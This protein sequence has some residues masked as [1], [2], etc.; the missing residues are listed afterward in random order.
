MVAANRLGKTDTSPHSRPTD[1]LRG[2]PSS[3]LQRMDVSLDRKEPSIT[4]YHNRSRRREIGPTV[5]GQ[6]WPLWHD[7]VNAKVLSRDKYSAGSCVMGEGVAKGRIVIVDDNEKLVDR[8]S[9]HLERD[10]SRM[11]TVLNAL[12]DL[13]PTR[14]RLPDL[15]ALDLLLPDMDG[16]DVCRV[17][18][19]E[20]NE[21]DRQLVGE[22]LT[23]LEI[24]GVSPCD[25]AEES[26]EEVEETHPESELP[27]SGPTTADAFLDDIE[28]DD[29]IGLYLREMACQPLLSHEEE[30]EL[31]KQMEQGNVAR[32]RLGQGELGAEERKRLQGQIEVAQEAR[33]RFIR[34]NTRLVVSIAKRYRNQGVPFLDLIQEGNLGLMKA[35]E[36]FDHQRG[37]RF[38][39]YATLWIRQAITRALPSQGRTVRIPMQMM[40]RMGRLYKTSQRMEQELG[41]WPTPE[42][43][44]R[45]MDL[46]PREVRFILGA[47]SRPI[48]LQT[49][50]G[51][52]DGELGDFVVDEL[53]DTPP[54]ALRQDS[55]GEQV[56]QVLATLTP[57]QAQVLRLRFGLQ[58]YQVCTLKEV[59][60]RFG[61]TRERIRQIQNQALRQLRHS[62]EA[63]PLCDY[64]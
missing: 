58:G 53:V 8:L 62:G 16:L 36:K 47:S 19:A 63:S 25:D 41:R 12:E 64:A 50:V 30:I 1:S 51:E 10:G 6:T 5:W 40:H 11:L 49:P 21:E 20:G 7:E 55:P 9:T 57:R 34:A 29:T 56:E 4:T 15:M 14:Y 13:E 43:V 18:R 60:E 32:E 39:T 2:L 59:G 17:P 35:V 38:S 26:T 31:A 23:F 33:G 48:S 27:E 52:E 42:E 46:E 61:L 54:E 44:A 28:A 45:E 3:R 22:V 24:H 37:N